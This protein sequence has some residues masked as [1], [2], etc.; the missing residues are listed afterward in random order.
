MRTIKF[1]GF[2][3]KNKK[4]VYG[5][6]LVNRGKHFICEDAIQVSDITWDDFL[7]KSDTIGQFTGLF[8][9]NKKE[10]YEGDI[11]TS[12]D[13]PFMKDKKMNYIAVVEWFE[14]DACWYAGYELHRDSNAR[15][16]SIGC[17]AQFDKDIAETYEVI[18][19]IYNNS[20]LIKK[21]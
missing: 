21:N 8:D 13:Y 2:N 3:E 6:Y 18:G 4:W 20:E 10:I 17:P 7:V 16:I 19:N 5:Y 14:Y 12:D 15:G 11:L 1:R 9:K